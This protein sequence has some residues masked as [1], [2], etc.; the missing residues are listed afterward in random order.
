M[1]K[2]KSKYPD[3]PVPHVV[4]VLIELIKHLNGTKREHEYE[5][6]SMWNAS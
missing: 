4:I 1:E 3:L 5:V 6:E 2:Q